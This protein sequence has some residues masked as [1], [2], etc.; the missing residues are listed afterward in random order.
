MSRFSG[1]CDLCDHINMNSDSYN[2]FDELR[3][4]EE[5]KR[6][7]GGVIHQHRKI[8]VS[9]YNQEFVKEHCNGFDFDERVRRIPDNRCLNRVREEKYFMYT[10]YGKEYTLK[11][12]NKRGVYITIDIKFNTLLDIIPYYPYVI[13]A[14]SSSEDSE[15]VVISTESETEYNFERSL[16]S[17]SIAHFPSIYNEDL[18]K[19]YLEVCRKYFLRDVESRTHYA[20]VKDLEKVDDFYV[21]KVDHEIDYMHDIEFGL[22]IPHWTHPELY[23]NDDVAHVG[24]VKLSSTDVEHFFSKFIESGDLIIKYV[25]KLNY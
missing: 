22:R 11:E 14:M 24:Y 2:E 12:L 25:S 23:K 4:F 5:F 19:H 1:K 9:T 17:G 21:L 10:Y 20:Q 7:T 8:V 3:N 18:Q 13:A 16:K 6:R 15:Y